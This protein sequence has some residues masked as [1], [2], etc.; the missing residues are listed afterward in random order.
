M[1]PDTL[2]H[3]PLPDEGGDVVMA[4]AGSDDQGHAFSTLP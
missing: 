4:E 2:S 1:P 3:A